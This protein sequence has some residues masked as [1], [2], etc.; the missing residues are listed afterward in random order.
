VGRS[1]VVSQVT[2]TERG[3]MKVGVSTFGGP[4][5]KNESVNLNKTYTHSAVGA[6]NK[7]RCSHVVD[8]VW[9]G[10]KYVELRNESL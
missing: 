7:Q 9:G 6:Y 10:S 1:S 5:E 4:S 8:K 3:R 2:P